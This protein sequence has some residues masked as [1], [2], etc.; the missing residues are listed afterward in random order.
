MAQPPKVYPRPTIRP[1]YTNT[2]S[3]DPKDWEW[4]A[5]KRKLPYSRR[6]ANRAV[7]LWERKHKQRMFKYKCDFCRKYHLT[8]N[9]QPTCS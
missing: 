6:D 8:K 7:N 3:M 2:G 1:A 9:W 4:W 5:C